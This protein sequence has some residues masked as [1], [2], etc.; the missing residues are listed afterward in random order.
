MPQ[1]TNLNISPYYDDFDKDDNFYKIL[2]KPGYPVQAREL[3]GLQS[4][5]QNQ[6]ESFGKHMFKEGSMVIPGNIEL[7]R[8]YF[9]AK[10][11]ETH[12]GIDVSIYLNELIGNNDGK[13]TRVRGQNSG[14]VATIKNYILPPAEGVDNI[15][16]FL[17]YQQSG[18]DGESKSF[19]DGEILILEEPLTYGNTTLT[20]GETVLT[21]TAEDATAVGSAF[22]VN[23]GVYFIRGSFV[24]V[25]SSLIIL[26]PYNLDPS[27]RVGFDIS[28]EV[29]NSNDDDS[30]YD[31]AK[32][33]TNFAAP[34]ADR[35]KIS[36]KLAKKALDDYEDTS[37]VE[38]MRVDGGEV[39]RL[40]D[41][42]S[43][44]EIKKYFAKRTFDESGDYAVE[45]F[46]VE[47]QESLNDEISTRGL[48][49]ENRLTD[50]GN[51][52][53]DDLMCVKLSPGRAYV[54]GFDVNLPGTTVLDVDKPRDTTT[55][56]SASIPFEMGSLLRVNNAQGTPFI[57]IGGTNANTIQL[58]NGRKGT[59]NAGGGIN[60]GDARVYSYAVTDASYSD[61]TTSFD[62]YLYDVQTYTILK[63]TS[64]TGSFIIGTKVRG[65]AS[66]AEGYL[67]KASGSTGVHELAVS[68][69]T[70]VFI[71]GERLIFNESEQGENV[72]IKDLNAY[73]IDDIKS[74]FQDADTLN[75]DLLSDF[76]A[77]T[78]LQ[79]I[80]LPGFSITDQLNITGNTATVNNR[81]FA[82]LVGIHT[83]AI[84]SYQRGDDFTNG[85]IVFNKINDISVDGKTL[86]LGAVE[87]VAGINTGAVLASGI[88]T[89]STFRLKVPQ[90]I[91]FESSGIYSR[92]P[93]PN[94][95]Q[96]DFADSHLI[97]SKQITGGPAII[98]NG[99][100][101]FNSS[102]GLTTAVGITSVFFEPFDAE[103]YS[104]HYSDGTT[105]PLTDDQVS[106]TNNGETITFAGLSK[107]SGNAVVNVTL[108]KLGV[109]SKSKDYVRSQK[110][111]VTRTAGISTLTSDLIPSAAYGLRVEDRQISLNVPDVARVIAVFESKNS[112]SPVLDKLKFVSGLT[113]D[114]ATIVGE[115]I[116][117]AES[118]AIGQLV[119]SSNDTVDFVYLND[120]VFTVGEE[121]LFKESAIK[122]ILQG[123]EVGNF[124]NRTNNYSL[125]KGHKDQ[126]CDYS[127]IIRK[128]K[129]AIPSKKLLIV[130]DHFKVASG[131]AGDLFTVNSY[132]EER[133]S[134]DI[135][136]L[137]SGISA[138]DILDFRPRVSP[139]NPETT[140]GSPF[141]FK[142]RSF[143]STNPFIITPNE[144]SLMGYGYYLGRIDKL[145]IDKDETVQVV[146]G[147]SS[148][149]PQPPA[150]NSDAMEIAEITLPPYLY[151]VET[152][153]TIILKDNR[154][155]T[156]RDIAALEKRI[157]NL[158]EMTSLSS[159]EL[160]TKSFQVRD[161]DG[162]DRFKTGFVVNDFKNRDFIDFNPE[163]GSRCDVDVDNEHLIT[164]VDFW[165][166]NPE[167]ALDPG[168]DI[169]TADLNSNLRLFDTNCKKTGDLITLDYEEVDWIE[170]PQATGVENVNPFNVIAFAGAIRLDPPSDNWS[171]T[172][173]INNERVESTG[174]R[175]V[176]ESRVVS[177][178]TERGRVRTS[179]STRTRVN[180]RTRFM[181]G[182]TFDALRRSGR[183]PG[184]QVM[185]I[186]GG[187][188]TGGVIERRTT[189]TRRQK[190]TRRVETAFQN[191]LRGSAKER[192]YVEST[193]ITSAADPYMRSRNVYFQASGL[194]PFT[195]HY[196]F[197]DSGIPDIVP[198]VFEI[199]MSSGTFTNFEDVQISI[200]GKRIGLIR[201]QAPNHKIG[202]DARPEFQAGLGSP[203]AN[204]EKY[205]VDPF[206]RS[207]PAPSA[208]Y[209]A[210]S[211]LFNCDVTGLAN[212]E[213]YFGYVVKG[214]KLTGKTSGAIATV[215]N[216][217]L[218]SDNWGDVIGAFFFR[219]A[220]KTPAPP[221]L[222]TSGTKTFKVTST[223]DGSIPL[224]ADLPLASS[225]TG[226]FL[227]TGT[228]ITQTNQ[229]VQ[230]RNPPKPPTRENEVVVN[231]RDVVRRNTRV[232]RTTLPRRRRRN[233][234][235]R[236]RRGRRDPLAQSFTVNET[237][238]FL[239]SFDVYFASKDENAK[240]TVQLATM[241]L[242][243]PTSNLVQDFS[244]IVLSPDDINISPDASIPTT[245]KFPSPVYL[246]PDEEYALI[247][248]C[249]SSDN[250]TMWVST[251]GE[252]S[253]RTTSLPDVQNVVVSKQYIGGSLFKSQNGTIWTPSQN[254]DL[255]FKLR[256]AK[257][258]ESGTVTMYNTPIEPGTLNTQNLVDNPLRSL[259]RKIKVTLSGSPASADYPAGRKI[260]TDNG[261]NATTTPEDQLTTG[262]I[263]GR[264]API[265]S[266]GTSRIEIVTG[267]TGYSFSSTTAV[268]LKSLTG[269]GIGA[270]AT[271]TVTDEVITGVNI[272]SVG[273][274]YQLGEVLTVDN[275]SVK[276]TRGGGFKVEIIAISAT[277]DTLFLTDV[278]GEKFTNGH[279]IVRYGVD[280]VTKTLTSVGVDGDSIVTGD[281]F[282]G[283]VFEVTQPNHAHHGATNKVEII[284]VEPDTTIVQTTSELTADG[285]VVSIANTAPFTSFGGITVDSGE[286][287]IE[288]EIVEYVVGVG[289]LTLTRGV[290]N[291]QPV[292]H[293][294]GA[295]IQVYEVAGMPLVGINT[296]FTV[297]TNQTLVNATNVDT[298]YLEVNV[299]GISARTGN[300]LLCFTNQKAFGGSNVAISQNHQY[301]SFDPQINFIT[302][303][304]LTSIDSSVRTISGTSAGGNE[305]SFLDQG[306]EPATLFQTTFFPTPRLIAS[307]IN[308]DKLT[309]FPKQKSIELNVN[310]STLDENLSPA[311]D[312]KNATFIYGRNKI[313][314]PIGSTNYATDSRVKGVID[315][316][317]G[318][319][320]VTEPVEL[321]NPATSLK[322]IV[323]AN[324]PPEADFRVF[325]RLFTADSSNTSSTYR[326]FPGH[327]NMKDTDGD[328]FG[329]EIVDVSKNDG[330]PDAFVSPSNDESFS[331]YRFSVNDLEPFTGFTIKIVMSSTNES[332]T[333][334][335]QDYRAIALA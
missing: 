71:K 281:L 119:S 177:D 67:A 244:E 3:T 206:D 29:I 186:F 25:Q 295:S 7:D 238:A 110:L 288:E 80:V 267:G 191:K 251:M 331:E 45:P 120:S 99:S 18:T 225:A 84:I 85:D 30:L 163:G 196:H 235:R 205:V 239:T 41:S 189:T 98:N 53:D 156:M 2:F 153:P 35:F 211:R 69:T 200:N 60:I 38:L 259:P 147:E 82:A 311:I 174:N 101:Q 73:T 234:R 40:Q 201:S 95:S 151:S 335:L 208:T 245:I 33:F 324:V 20:I 294:E 8:S 270:E 256:K 301:S 24:D 58:F 57:N 28:E 246:P 327:L 332:A 221:T 122:T 111:E 96:V 194:K 81:N 209:S 322:V 257:F 187:W 278:Q 91:N 241:E 160:D 170:N 287:L 50:E 222:F 258:V 168:I 299:S 36:V 117:G 292:T 314:N 260:T 128:E 103:R 46:R 181:R 247:F 236:R 78:I 323:G 184:L 204:L 190:V 280:N 293:P 140:S 188:V 178:R 218:F 310:M 49:T 252:K 76:S 198:K 12:L 291:T 266:T 87:H 130:F 219:D 243:I 286:A 320:F 27:Y 64:F 135:P 173:Y 4:L 146:Q 242:G 300:Q 59:T 61:A 217:A 21:L 68:E 47:I 75:S 203:N 108:K 316:P 10:I 52:P 126:Y 215:T 274:G 185:G 123:V 268:P 102:V 26:D 133:Y 16:V 6:V 308:E 269:T 282:T 275:D 276:V 48:F 303:G 264:G 250:Y 124:T 285:T 74:V 273:S 72:S 51:T 220:N 262:I 179:R 304:T 155:F 157:E 199:E 212:L 144:S 70:G 284:D 43:Y 279:K 93:Q 272:T 255:T 17:K 195:R 142:N 333:V 319:L 92:L 312:M 54:K 55:V 107:S 228:V 19:P 104:I 253:V 137:N 315:D 63:T 296:F 125:V 207:R 328:G 302:P 210:T 62:L 176:E 44:S 183:L 23:A 13:G 158:E 202:D 229:V 224:P 248:I 325:Y 136:I 113:L 330:R 326:A 305:I 114:T 116:V 226:T 66:G 134:K 79:D 106:I 31:N 14:I 83:D 131:N 139:F 317:H 175:W 192:D 289:Q 77:D 216:V 56:N 97:I 9:S 213:K 161:K 141:A 240:L 329:D 42:S 149:F 180:G 94:I 265:A 109:T 263:E 138:S 197:L 37:F 182:R 89:T 112:S 298:Y 88:S 121:V 167:L 271:I 230:L 227:G 132:T 214:A 172:I 171:R 154:R 277:L 166:M 232:T 65:L 127:Q 129:S 261:T 86:T 283:N 254:Q 145:I 164:A 143:E 1:K 34:G 334:K 11:N 105:E 237:G 5:L 15:T 150:V 100:I 233:W 152:E 306:Y 193:K 231:T 165:S 290:L 118:R 313:N 249:P 169:S 223:V 90:L 159:L 39:K 318:T 309:F 148:E 162:L 307:T 321:D 115:Q 297:P 32:G 22:G